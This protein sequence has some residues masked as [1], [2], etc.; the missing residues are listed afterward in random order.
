[1]WRANAAVG[2]SKTASRYQFGRRPASMFLDDDDHD[3][4][5]RCNAR[6]G[7]GCVLHTLLRIG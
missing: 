1:M 4:S 2:V 7:G 5:V 3:E 6:T